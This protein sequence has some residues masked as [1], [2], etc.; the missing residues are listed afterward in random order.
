MVDSLNSCVELHHLIA[1]HIVLHGSENQNDLSLELKYDVVKT[2][3]R[4]SYLSIRKL[5]EIFQ[6][7]KTRI[8][9]IL[10]GKDKIV[11]MYENNASAELRHTRKR[12]CESKY[13][14]V[15]EALYPWYLLLS[16]RIFIL[17]KDT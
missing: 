1:E 8:S 12:V 11:R 6:C 14:D 4:E 5:A 7:G 10:K 9:T 17:M 16:R 3:E 13:S 15:N 2:S